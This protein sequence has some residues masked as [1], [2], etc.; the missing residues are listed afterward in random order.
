MVPTLNASEVVV[1]VN[2]TLPQA[3]VDPALRKPVPSDVVVQPVEVLSLTAVIRLPETVM[4]PL[5]L[6]CVIVTPA[7][8]RSR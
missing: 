7:V 5:L 6:A 4:F 2:F 3:A 1:P 8:M